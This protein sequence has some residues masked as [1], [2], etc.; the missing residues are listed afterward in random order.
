MQR[1]GGKPSLEADESWMGEWVRARTVSIC[2][3][4]LPVCWKPHA[5][6]ALAKVGQKRVCERPVRCPHVGCRLWWSDD[7]RENLL[8]GASSIAELQIDL[9]ENKEQVT[10]KQ[11][12]DSEWN[13]SSPRWISVHAPW[14]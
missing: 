6:L 8:H 11:A 10:P 13:A 5:T 1:G 12:S 14:L 2:R 4:N 9:E 3:E 7:E